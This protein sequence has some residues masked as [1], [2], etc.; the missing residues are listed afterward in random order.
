MAQE[1]A[2]SK[3]LEEYILSLIFQAAIKDKPITIFWDK[4]I[5]EIRVMNLVDNTDVIINPKKYI[6]T[7]R[8]GKKAPDAK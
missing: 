2:S 8:S 3:T 4:K 6:E 5:K 1:I 7:I